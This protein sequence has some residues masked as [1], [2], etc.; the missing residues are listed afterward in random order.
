LEAIVNTKVGVFATRNDAEAAVKELLQE[1]VPQDAIVFLTRDESEP[2]VAGTTVGVT[3]GGAAGLSLGVAAATVMAVPGI[4]QVFALGFGA[5]ALLGLVGAGSGA[6][7]GKAVDSGGAGIQPSTGVSSEND[8]DRYRGPLA[9]GKS[10]VI[11]RT[12]SAEVEKIASR[13]LNR[14]AI[15]NE[16]RGATGK[17]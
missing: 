3:L 17:A 15:E 11:V 13:I 6:A 12:E 7:I 2:S 5:A 14:A 1:G 16:S 10:L 4:G 9:D 8:A